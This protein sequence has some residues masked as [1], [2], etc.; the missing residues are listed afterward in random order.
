[1]NLPTSLVVVG[2][3]AI[4]EEH[5]KAAQSLGALVSA[6]FYKDNPSKAN[7][8]A[9]KYGI[10]VVTNRLS[11]L[12]SLSWDRAVVA[13]PAEH[14]FEVYDY[15]ALTSKPVLFEKPV[16]LDKKHLQY[17]SQF[18][19][20]SVA[21]NR[22]HYSSV[23]AAKLFLSA[24]QPDLVRLTLTQMPSP[25]SLVKNFYLDGI[26]L[27]D[28]LRFLLPKV[29]LDSFTARQ[30]SENSWIAIGSAGET[31][32]NLTFTI[33]HPIN[34]EIMFLSKDQAAY[35]RPIEVF[36]IYHGMEKHESASQG[37][38]RYEPRLITQT[39]GSQETGHKS[40]FLEQMRAFL[41]LKSPEGITA[42]ATISDV[43][44]AFELVDWVLADSALER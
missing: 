33:G 26:H 8:L 1:M 12:G 28:L 10:G 43:Q 6:V 36:N 13:I 5:I 25:D 17:L 29:T 34:H 24:D 2:A 4:A 7:L 18:E 38:A 30:D 44:K 40:G 15:L 35:L 16:S 31:V 42:L 32:L 22:R 39:I 41:N 20:I 19:N 11:L 14:T 23:T 21:L 37:A 9:K 3:G 27:I